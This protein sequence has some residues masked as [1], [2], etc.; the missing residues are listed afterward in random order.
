MNYPKWVVLQITEHCNLRCKMCYE[1]GENGSYLDKKNLHNL[2][3]NKIEEIFS[4]LSNKNT[5]FELFGGEPLMH[6]DFSHIMELVKKYNCKIDIPTNGTLLSKYAEKIVSAQVRRIW[7]SLDGPEEI[8]DAQRGNGV[9][10]RATEGIKKLQSL[11]KQYN[12]EYPWIGAT[13]VL[14]PLNYTYLKSFVENELIPLNLDYIS[15]EFQLYLTQQRYDDYLEYLSKDMNISSKSVASGLIRNLKDFENIDLD[16]LIYQV[17]E[18]QKLILDNNIKLI[19]Y[20]NYIEKE[21]LKNFYSGNWD[22][23]KEKK[24]SCPFP[25]IYMEVAANGDVTPCHTFYDFKMGNVYEKRI[26]DI[27]NDSKYLLFRKH[28]KKG[29]T[30]L[31]CACSRYY[32]KPEDRK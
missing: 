17:K 6:P 12:S 22:M 7:I 8:N 1:W 14:T 18:A 2:S 13:F 26:L 29:I 16:E 30:P 23:M 27:W 4:D 32:D 19:G 21:N 24:K 31:C 10:K 20:P 15:I 25:W 3:L 9:Y 28:L 5:Y 11:K